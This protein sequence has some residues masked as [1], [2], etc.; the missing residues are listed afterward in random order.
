MAL[1]QL[2]WFVIGFGRDVGIYGRVLAS[3]QFP[4]LMDCEP[5]KELF[6]RLLT[7]ECLVTSKRHYNGRLVYIPSRSLGA[8]KFSWLKAQVAAV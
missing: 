6:W 4:A 7:R 1:G 5:A 8:H 2:D 3:L